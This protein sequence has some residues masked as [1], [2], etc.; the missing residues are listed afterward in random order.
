MNVTSSRSFSVPLCNKMSTDSLF[1][2]NYRGDSDKITFPPPPH[3]HFKLLFP[4]AHQTTSLASTLLYSSPT[5]RS[6]RRRKKKQQERERERERKHQPSLRATKL[7]LLL[8]LT[9]YYHSLLLTTSTPWYVTERPLPL[10]KP[11]SRIFPSPPGGPLGGN[12]SWLRWYK[13]LP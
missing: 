4:N 7:P 6:K 8:V 9:I 2:D 1:A 5:P 11:A 13:N 12:T 3:C 10:D